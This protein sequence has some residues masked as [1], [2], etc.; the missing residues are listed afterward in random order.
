MQLVVAIPGVS[1]VGWI[2]VI[3]GLVII[4]G[5][6]TGLV[7][8][9]LEAPLRTRIAAAEAA[10]E[11]LGR[12][13]EADRDSYADLD[14]RYRS[15]QQDFI[16]LKAEKVGAIVK[17]DID[18][19]LLEAMS[20]LGTNESSILVPGPSPSSPSFVFLSIFGP[21]SS[22]L[23]RSK[24]PIDRG[25]VGRVYA[26]GRLHNAA[27]AYADPDFFAGVDKKGAHETRALLALPLIH[28]GQVVGVAQFLN[29]PG[30]FTR[31]DALA[32]ETLV[33]PLAA[34]VVRFAAD[35]ENFGLLGL[36]WRQE[37]RDATIMFC[38]LTASSSLVTELSTPGAVDCINEYLVQQCEIAIGHGAMVDKYLGDGAMFRFHSS[39]EAV[40]GDHVARAVEAALQMRSAHT[41]L[42][43]GWL[44]QGLPV[45][46][47]YSRIGIACGDV[48]EATIG[49]PEH[50]QQ[51]TVIGKAVNDA[52]KLCEIASRNRNSIVVDDHLAG[53]LRGRFSVDALGSS[54]YEVLARV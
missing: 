30:G 44:S 10:K 50:N 14:V 5:A 20:L 46:G 2:A 35:P 54:G 11:D 38:D 24:L 49:H 51:I 45:S 7:M 22:K 4:G 25:I 52:A 48:Y 8:R 34:K 53:R 42:R 37:G 1:T 36:A 3:S 43:M 15:L 31:D 47:N 13:L 21:A 9:M 32:A 28:A 19:G 23:R 39:R 41:E 17:N 6:C 12:R 16:N 33:E 27:D 26:T 40:D 18:E 29:K